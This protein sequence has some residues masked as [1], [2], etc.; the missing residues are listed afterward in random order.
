VREVFPPL[1]P[2]PHAD[3]AGLPAQELSL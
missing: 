2:E 1:Q 3:R